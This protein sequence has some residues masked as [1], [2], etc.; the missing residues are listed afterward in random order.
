MKPFLTL[1][2]RDF[3]D[4]RG[5]LLWTPLVT[6]GVVA[7]LALLGLGSS[8]SAIA[9]GNGTISVER[10][11][12][13]DAALALALST[14]F[15]A[16]V[17]VMVAGLVVIFL[18]AGALYEERKDRSI[19]FWKSLP[20]GDHATAAARILTIVALGFAVALAS[21]LVLHAVVFIATA[22]V[23]NSIMPM[24]DVGKAAL[25]A[26]S[27]WPA[28]LVVVLVYV[29][30]AL[31]VYGWLLLVGASVLKAPL[32]AGLVPLIVLPLAAALSRLP[33][34]PF[35]APLSRL[36]G[37]A[38]FPEEGSVDQLVN[39]ERAQMFGLDFVR[40]TMALVVH[41]VTQPTWWIG[42]VVAGALVWGAGEV[43]RRR[44]P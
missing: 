44:A 5:A 11:P 15:T 25:L 24:L 14:Q 23:L 10:S 27:L 34:E 12:G 6:A 9:N 43:R 13:D 2:R 17:P 18:L 32:A 1:V 39:M 41:A 40:E 8:A 30:W 7:V 20:V 31:P 21:A 26:V 38:M 16:L 36:G 3:A 37:V 22:A 35:L 19:L 42:L 28:A 29:S 33:A 4:H